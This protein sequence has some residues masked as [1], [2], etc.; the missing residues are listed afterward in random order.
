[1]NW[2]HYKKFCLMNKTHLELWEEM[3][4]WGIEKKPTH[5]QIEDVL[6]CLVTFK[7]ESPITEHS[8]HLFNK[9]AI[10]LMKYK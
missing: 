10:E 1:M 3:I 7:H 8:S 9:L 4:D 6:E 5:P 2:D